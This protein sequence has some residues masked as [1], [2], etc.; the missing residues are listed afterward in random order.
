MPTTLASPPPGFVLLVKIFIDPSN[1][2]AF[3]KAFKPCYDAVIAEP[4]CKFFEVAISTDV[5]GQ[6]TFWEGWTIGKEEFMEVRF[7]SLHVTATSRCGPS[8]WH[9]QGWF[10]VPSRFGLGRTPLVYPPRP[11]AFPIIFLHWL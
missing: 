5:P 11:H 1:T 9:Y 8:L 4:E 2:D 3:L 10:C 7:E 6:F